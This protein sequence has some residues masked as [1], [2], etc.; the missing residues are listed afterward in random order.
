MTGARGVGAEM[1]EVK[2]KIAQKCDQHKIE[3]ERLVFNELINGKK[4]ADG[5]KHIKAICIGIIKR[6][7]AQ[8]SK[9]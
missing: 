9:K 8:F 4:N 1:K 5:E 3:A 2:I 7:G 6:G